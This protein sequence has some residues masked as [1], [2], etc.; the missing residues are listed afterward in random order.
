MTTATRDDRRVPTKTRVEHLT[1]AERVARG[2]AARADVPRSAHAEFDPGPERPDPVALLERQA[3]TRVPELVPIRYGRMLVSPFTFYRGA[4]LIMAADLATTPTTG[5]RVQLCGDA[6]LSNF[7]VFGTPERRMDF[8]V[9]DFDETLPGPFEW[10]VKRLAA[11]LEV[12]GRDRGFA[13]A[14]RESGGP[15]L[16]GQLPQRHGRLRRAEQPGD[17]LRAPGRR[18]GVR[19]LPG[20]RAAQAGSS[21]PRRGWPRRAPR[22]AC[23]PSPS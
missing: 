9:N 20:H 2:Q 22:T 18:R 17:L 14:D 23:R 10:D 1:V 8:D 11:S 12:A 15:G 4:A 5:L 16:R 13:D 21:A 3:K 19:P 7:G 6:H